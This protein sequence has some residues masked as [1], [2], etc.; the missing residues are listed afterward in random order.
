MN[1]DAPPMSEPPSDEQPDDEKRDRIAQTVTHT[2]DSGARHTTLQ[3]E[4]QPITAR[5]QV[6]AEFRWEHLSEKGLFALRG[7]D[8]NTEHWRDNPTRYLVVEMDEEI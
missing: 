3:Y 4:H 1:H 2:C 7:S 5:A 6:L 8:G